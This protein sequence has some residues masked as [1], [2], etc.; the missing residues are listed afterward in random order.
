MT[1]K[2]IHLIYSIV[3]G[4]MLVVSGLCLITACIGIYN[5]GDRP[6]SREAV[7]AA[8]SGIAIPVYLCLALVAGGIIL[9]GFFPVPRKNAAPDKQYPVIL[10][11]LHSKLDMGACNDAACS[12]IEAQQKNRRLHKWISLILLVLGSVIF[13]LYGMNSHNFDQT[14]ITGSMISAMYLFL[15]CLA[16]PFGYAVFC[17]YFTR[18]SLQKEIALVKAAIAEGAQTSAKPQAQAKSR[19][20]LLLALR[21]SL[22]A[23]GIAI[24]I[25][26]FFA[27][28]TNDVLTKAI[29]ICTECVGLG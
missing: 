18:R 27:G 29:N 4:V 16:V 8:F 25:Y 17:A 12:A 11:R 9:D 26:G 19:G 20:R 28:G 10:A 7:A 15:P 23:V 1:K 5:A 3:L 13:L 21:Y 24:L 14:D 2:R 6:F 22:L